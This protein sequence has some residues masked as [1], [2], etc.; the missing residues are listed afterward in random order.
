MTR[1]FDAFSAMACGPP[2]QVPRTRPATLQPRFYSSG[3]TDPGSIHP[4]DA[5]PLRPPTLAADDHTESR[6]NA[7][8]R[9]PFWFLPRSTPK[10]KRGHPQ[11][12]F[13]SDG[14]VEED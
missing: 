9:P 14:V 5:E 8:Q 12:H 7:G 10:T 6:S 1:A 13:A 3:P 11:H 2:L 4:S